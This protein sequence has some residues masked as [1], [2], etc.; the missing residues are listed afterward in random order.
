MATLILH[1]MWAETHYGVRRVGQGQ[2]MAIV[3]AVIET[4]VEVAYVVSRI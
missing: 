3:M 4:A 1:V 2:T